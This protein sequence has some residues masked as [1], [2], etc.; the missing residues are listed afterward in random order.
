MNFINSAAIVAS[1]LGLD[2]VN[3]L[4]PVSFKFNGKTRTHYGLIAQDIETVL[5]DIGKSTT[6]F[7]GFIK[8]TVDDDGNP[9]DLAR[10]GLR[11]QEFISPMIKAIQELSAE[12]SAL[13]A[14]VAALEGWPLS[15]Y[16]I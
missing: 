1:D 7:A 6:N 5:A 14:R 2:F 13:K 8:D 10:Y 12:N 9:F 4:T 11:Y 3:K 16:D 15:Y